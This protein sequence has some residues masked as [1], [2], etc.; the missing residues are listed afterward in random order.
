MVI[1]HVIK[2]TIL[3]GWKYLVSHM[4]ESKNIRD[5]ISLPKAIIVLLKVDF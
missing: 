1:S 2:S 3:I 5:L 4:A